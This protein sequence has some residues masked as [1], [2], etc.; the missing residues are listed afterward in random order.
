MWNDEI[1]SQWKTETHIRRQIYSVVFP[2]HVIFYSLTG[3]H[4]EVNSSDYWFTQ[5]TTQPHRWPAPGSFTPSPLAKPESEKWRSRKERM[6]VLTCENIMEVSLKVK[7]GITKW[8][9]AWQPA[10]T[11]L[12]CIHT[13]DMLPYCGLCS[14]SGEARRNVGNVASEMC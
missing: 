6:K 11:F 8:I 9:Q 4:T 2:S 3:I 12:F 10:G 13:L 7:T 5:E 14:H 1:S